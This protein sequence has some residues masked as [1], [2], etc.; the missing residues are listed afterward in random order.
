[1]DFFEGLANQISASLDTALDN[2]FDTGIPELNDIITKDKSNQCCADCD[3]PNPRWVQLDRCIF[4]CTRC[5]GVHGMLSGDPSC[6]TSLRVATEKSVI[7][8][9]HLK[10]LRVG[11]NAVSNKKLLQAAKKRSGFRYDL[12][13]INPNDT[14]G[15]CFLIESKYSYV[16]EDAPCSPQNQLPPVRIEKSP[17]G[18]WG[19]PKEPQVTPP[20]SISTAP[21][22]APAL[23]FATRDRQDSFADLLS[24]IPPTSPDLAAQ[25]IS[26]VAYG[27]AQGAV[28][29]AFS[30]P[31]QTQ[32]QPRMP[33][34]QPNLL[35]PQNRPAYSQ[36]PFVVQPQQQQQRRMGGPPMPTIGGQVYGQQQIAPAGFPQQQM[37]QQMQQPMQPQGQQQTPNQVSPFYNPNLYNNR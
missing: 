35:A 24:Q 36:S 29:S 26:P 37:Q 9:V 7:S 30:S 5:A 20:P 3:K 14:A 6:V 31:G 12:A 19:A 10:T 18:T 28:M 16:S 34:Q 23:T 11:G 21:E 1:M 33:Y 25:L 2:S 17:K 8:S 27:Q 13:K 22:P 15:I 32:P 4:L